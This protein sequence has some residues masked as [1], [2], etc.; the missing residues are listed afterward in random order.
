VARLSTNL[1]QVDSGTVLLPEFQRG[2]VWNRDQVRG[3]MRSL[4]R[5][6]PVGSLL[7]WETEADPGAIRG[8]GLAAAGIR[9]LLL[10]GQQRIT[11]LY[12]IV[13]GRPPAFFEGRPETLHGLHFHVGDE[14]F[15]FYAP[16]K[17]KGDPR[18]VDVSKLF[19][20]GGPRHHMAEFH[21]DPH[22]DD[23]DAFTYAQRLMKLYGLLDKDFH[24]E[25]ITGS[26]MTV[27]SVVDIFNKVNSGGTKLSQGDLALAKICAQN[28][29]VRTE[30]RAALAR[31]AGAGYTFK[32]DWL[33]RNANAVITGRAPFGALDGVPSRDFAE[34]L[35]RAVR[36]V[37]TFLQTVQGR[38]G[39]DHDRVLMGRYA[40]P[41]ISRHLDLRGG[42]FADHRERDAALYWYVSSAIWGRF[43]GS[44]ETVLTRDYDVV[45]REGIAGLI[46]SLERWRGGNLRLGPHDFE[47]YGV[48]SRFYPLLYLMTRV[49]E[50]R[51]L[52]TGNPL[53]AEM[54]GHLAGL[55]VHH[56]FPKAFLY[57]HGYP[58]HLV[59]SVSNFAFLTQ[60]TNLRI[61]MRP[62]AE[63]LAEVA[64][65][66]PGALQSQWIPEDPDLWLPDN[67]R[68]FLAAR[69]T[70]LSDAANAFLDRLRGG[71]APDPGALPVAAPP[72][73][74]EVDPRA[75]EVARAVAELI[76]LGCV[77]PALDAEICDPDTGRVLA[78]AE[79]L[80]AEGLQPGI[81]SPVLLELDPDDADLARLQELGFEVFNSASALV[82]NV[83]RQSIDAAE[84]P[85]STGVG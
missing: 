60:E 58:Q 73:D 78:V 10:D 26:E 70:L 8:D 72:V 79:A 61:G 6:Y 74:A 1:D 44:V 76:E 34:G 43:T 7:V 30:M 24:Q 56:I 29:A 75:Q 25:K 11:T 54:L 46:T 18:W 3:L 55:Q 80:W 83:R 71:M 52:G 69:Q 41:V 20:A 57:S 35:G 67:Y 22:I 33:L 9:L 48:G 62:P 27:E 59:N 5:G 19:A 38:L 2:Y 15:E 28:P 14:T 42:H 84:V 12:G 85:L 36:H 40:V 51:D 53:R 68:D 31:W 50:A 16:A 13:R 39:L 81:G 63:Y 45:E 66:H 64:E 32:L 47:G 17:M 21:A 4:Y 82:G 77:A 37:E 65:R 49:L 23:D